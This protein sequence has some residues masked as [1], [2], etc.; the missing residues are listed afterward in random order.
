M[1][2]PKATKTR[3][4]KLTPYERVQAKLFEIVDKG[5]SAGQFHVAVDA[6]RAILDSLRR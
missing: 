2:K 1:R 3:E 4:T 5:I 6:A